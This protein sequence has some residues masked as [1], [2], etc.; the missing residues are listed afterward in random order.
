MQEEIN[1]KVDLRPPNDVILRTITNIVVIIILTF[2]IFLF[3]SGH[4]NPGGGFVGGL[5][6]AATIVLMFLVYGIS[7]VRKNFPVNLK[8]V[9]GAGVLL[10]V[11]TGASG[12]LWGDAFLTHRAWVFDLPV[13]G[14]TE[15]STATIF[16]VGV[17]LAVIGTALTIIMSIGD[18]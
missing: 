5:A 7:D 13:F 16:D 11:L 4:H 18:D 14:L 9:A 12:M 3:F 8:K 1:K 10:A 2:A 6:F 17:A 15:L